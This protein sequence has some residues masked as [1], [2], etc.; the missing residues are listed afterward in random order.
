MARKKEYIEKEVI[1]K[2][3]ELFWRNGYE[4]TS[5]RE[6]EKV[7]GINKFSIYSSFGSKQ[8]VFLESIKCYKNKIQSIIDKLKASEKGKESIKDFFYDFLEF[9][10]ENDISKGCLLTSTSSEFGA[11]GDEEIMSEVFGFGKKLKSIFIEKLKLDGNND[12]ELIMKQANFLLIAK[13]GLSN[14]SKVFD[15]KVIEDFIEITFEKI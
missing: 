13:Q 10:K 6:L 3:T 5:M 9:S 7:M 1:E 2:A 4:M 15:H 8:G 12:E 11:D 14:A